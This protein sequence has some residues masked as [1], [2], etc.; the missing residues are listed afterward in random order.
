LTLGVIALQ[1]V[2]KSGI[3]W[4]DRVAV[5]G[6]GLLGDLVARIAR[7]AGAALVT[8]F[9]RPELCAGSMKATQESGPLSNGDGG[10]DI[11][12]DVTGNPAAVVDASRLVTPGGRIVLVGSSRGISPVIPE[13]PK[14]GMPVEIRGA[15]AQMRPRL[16]STPGRWTFRDEGALYLDWVSAGS[17]HFPEPAPERVDPREAWRFYRRLGL[18][19]PRVFAALFDW[20]GIPERQRCRTS[21]LSLPGAVLKRGPDARRQTARLPRAIRGRKRARAYK[22]PA[23]PR[24]TEGQG[25]LRMAM[26]G[27]GEIALKNAQAVAE[28]GVAEVRWAIDTNLPLAR[29]LARRFGGHA[30]GDPEAALNDAD[31]NAVFICTPHHLHAPIGLR[32]VEAGKHVVVEKPLARSAEEAESLVQAASRAKVVL[33]TCY[34]MRFLPQVVAART[35]V[36]EGGLGRI[37]GMKIA[38]N[39]YRAMSYWHG[40]STGRSRSNWRAFREQSGGGV[41][42][43]NLCHHLDVL[44]FVTDLRVRRVYCEFD[45]FAAPGD[46]EDLVALTVRM[47]DGS[48]ASVDASTCAP[49]GGERAF[50]IWGTD[51]QVALDDP[52]R[53]LSLKETSVGGANEWRYL[54][55]GGEREARKSFVRAFAGAVAQESSNPAPPEAALAVQRLIDAAYQSGRSG[56]PVD[57]TRIAEAPLDVVSRT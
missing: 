22:L 53:F 39:L 30:A 9:G 17:L 57:V 40:G 46:V 34:P 1:G 19:E 11:A 5:L 49:G 10:F 15:H 31:V 6:R 47:T 3:R 14:G 29:D 16:L 24:G 45:R 33:S 37:V 8:T 50:Q 23:Q 7:L 4:G 13:S 52:P 18:G 48:I 36:Q 55:V 54:P 56:Q 32:A 21:S 12:F 43:M 26:I 27:C 42:L 20:Q 28:S 35:L 51:G 2:R 25:M 44:L 41:L 38:E